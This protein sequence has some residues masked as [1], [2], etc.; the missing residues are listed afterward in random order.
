[1]RNFYWL[2][3]GQLAG[4]SR[5]GWDGT[6]ARANGHG[7]PGGARSDTLAADLAYLRERGITA[8]LSLTEAPLPTDALAAAGI[9]TCHV[10]IGDMTAPTPEQL[11]EGLAFVDRQL[12]LGHHVAVHCLVGEGRTGT[13]L[14]AYLIRTGHT[15]A[16]AIGELRALRAGAITSEEQQRALRAYAARRDWIA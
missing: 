1:M 6:P 11:E 2:I 3:E 8:L 13:L 14:A 9:A 7:A 5:P 12:A 10:P 15:P 16:A 4:C